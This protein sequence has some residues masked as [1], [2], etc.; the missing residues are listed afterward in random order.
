RSTAHDDRYYLM[1]TNRPL[2]AA[3]LPDKSSISPD[4]TYNQFEYPYLMVEI[5]GSQVRRFSCVFDTKRLRS[6]ADRALIAATVYDGNGSVAL[7]MIS[8]FLS[9]NGAD[10]RADT[11]VLVRRDSQEFLDLR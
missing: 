10:K 1:M 8:R 2:D 11:C 6:A 7:H 3:Y 4:A 9:E 5:S